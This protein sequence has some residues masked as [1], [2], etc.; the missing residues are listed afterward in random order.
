MSFSLPQAPGSATAE[1]KL[2]SSALL[3]RADAALPSR[4]VMVAA[5]SGSSHQ[6]AIPAVGNTQAGFVSPSFGHPEM[7]HL[8][9]SCNLVH[10]TRAQMT[11]VE[12]HVSLYQ[13]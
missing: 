12:G 5:L 13:L 7:R 11:P 2:A 6:L 4:Y 9:D 1:A 8:S 10:N 3:N